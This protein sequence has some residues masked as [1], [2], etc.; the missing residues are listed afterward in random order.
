MANYVLSETAI[1]WQ[2]VHTVPDYVYFSH[3][4]HVSLAEIG[5]QECHGKVSE[6][7]MPF[8][9]AAMTMD[10]EWCMDCHEENEV[11]ND[12]YSCHR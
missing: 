11:T 3:R 2:E 10:M 12:C 8:T 4:R 1:P 9:S 7:K 6:M 5:C